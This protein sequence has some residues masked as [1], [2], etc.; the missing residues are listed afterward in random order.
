MSH[1]SSSMSEEEEE[2]EESMRESEC[3][4]AFFCLVG[5][6]DKHGATLPA[7]SPLSSSSD[8]VFLNHSRDSARRN[9]GLFSTC[10]AVGV[11]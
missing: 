4:P 7:P 11:L 5:R 8:L 3:F 10:L 9:R 2:E 1:S 6:I